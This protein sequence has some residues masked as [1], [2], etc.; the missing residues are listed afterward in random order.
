MPAQCPLQKF[1][2][3]PN[4]TELKLK[5]LTGKQEQKKLSQ[6]TLHYFENGSHISNKRKFVR[7]D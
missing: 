2:A 5:E 6:L 4:I 7:F 3:D 1:L